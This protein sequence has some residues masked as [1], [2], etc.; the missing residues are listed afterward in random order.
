[1]G[2]ARIP[3]V[4]DDLRPA[5]DTGP[6]P[7][8][9]PVPPAVVARSVASTVNI[10]SEGCGGL[11]EGSGFVID[12]DT[13]VTNAHV[14][15]GG[16]TIRARRPDGRLVRAQ[17]VV[18]D[19]NRDLAVLSA[20]GLGLQPLTMASASEGTEGAV[21]GYPGG[22]NRVRVAPAVVR[23]EVT[24]TGRD[25]YSRDRTRRRVLILASALRPGDS[26]AAFI[27]AGGRVVGVAFAIAPDRSATAYA[28]DDTELRAVLAAPRRPGV[29]PCI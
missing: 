25:I 21:L 7:S 18:F 13:V 16:D 5:P 28:V 20:P 27:D 1:M 23:Q 17:V 11:H 2:D 29:G 4:F 22:Q 6:P 19:D 9:V 26:G 14:V 15:A 24:A 8:Q 3:D 12:R 10:E